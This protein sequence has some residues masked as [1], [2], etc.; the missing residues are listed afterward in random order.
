MFIYKGK[1]TLLKHPSRFDKLIQPFL[2][3]LLILFIVAGVVVRG[4]VGVNG[5]LSIAEGQ[6]AEAFRTDHG[7]VPL[8]FRLRLDDFRI[9]YYD[10]DETDSLLVRLGTEDRLRTIPIELGKVVQLGP[11]GTAVEV[12]RRVL[13][14][15]RD[16]DRIFSAS[17][18]PVN[19]AIEVRLTGPAGE[20]RRWLFAKFFNFHSNDPRPDG[21]EMRYVWPPPTVKAF[22]SHVTALSEQG[23]VLRKA[24]ILVNRPLKVGRYTLY[25]VSYDRETETISILKAT[26][27][28]GMPLV[29]IG[30]ALL[31]VGVA[32]TF[33]VKPFLNRKGRKHV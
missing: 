20:S 17:D 12:L 11:D 18:K 3:G 33:Y 24:T 26:Y 4:M 19:P 16:G 7:V 6:T 27:D 8:G 15:M 14:F 28:P 5:M 22:E 9:R 23:E 25:Q 10:E 1:I 2:H 32:F 21:V 31:P 30:F 13:H 29:F